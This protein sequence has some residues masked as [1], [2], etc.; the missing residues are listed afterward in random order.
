MLVWIPIY[1]PLTRNG[2]LSREWESGIRS[3][4]KG[5]R[6]SGYGWSRSARAWIVSS[7]RYLN[8][9]YLDL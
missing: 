8:V 6:Q 4:Q 2:Y 1:M 7:I 3:P 9:P 5:D